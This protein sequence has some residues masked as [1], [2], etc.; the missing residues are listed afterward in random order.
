MS[1]NR[2]FFKD[3]RGKTPDWLELYNYSAAPCDLTGWK[4]RQYGHEG[5][6]VDWPFPAGTSI[7]PRE[8][9]VLFCRTGATTEAAA[10]VKGGEDL[11]ATALFLCPVCGN[12]VEGAPPDKCAICGVPADK[13]VEIQ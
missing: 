10:A 13:F 8:H 6:V 9:A 4:L 3:A 2:S 7:G 11:P 1:L 5:E 12:T